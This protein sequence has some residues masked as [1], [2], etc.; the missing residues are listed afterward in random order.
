M[1]DSGSRSC[2]MAA[3]RS[4]ASIGVGEG[5]KIYALYIQKRRVQ[6]MAVRARSG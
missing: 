4:R 3:M 6:V 1:L 2:S 5:H